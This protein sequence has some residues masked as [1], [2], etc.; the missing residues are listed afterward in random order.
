MNK[1]NY[2]AKARFY[3][4]FLCRELP[5]IYATLGPLLGL[6]DLADALGGATLE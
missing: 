3:L 5:A 2:T 6:P 1:D 4:D